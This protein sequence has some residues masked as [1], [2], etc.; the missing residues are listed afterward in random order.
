MK[1]FYENEFGKLF[2]GDCLEIMAKARDK[3]VDMI[4]CDLPY[5]VT[6]QNKWDVVIPFE[7]LWKEYERIIKDKGAIVLTATQ[8]FATDLIMSN[9]KLFRYDLIWYKALGTGHLNCNRMPMRNHEHILLFYKK[10]PTY[11]PQ[12]E[13]GRMRT[14]GSLRGNTTTNYGNFE[15]VLSENDTYYPQSVIDISNGDR[16]GTKIVH[17][18]QKPV[19]LFEWLIKTYSN[20]MDLILDNCLG[21]GTTAIAAQNLNRKWIGIEK[22]E[23]YCQIAKERIEALAIKA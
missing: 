15:G 3:S 14:K 18:T 7:S 4:L 10:L 1:P 19:E 8:P 23:K 5:G 11:N 16:N 6:A 21:S 22:E 9:R 13:K 20:E 17:P 2:H 12:K